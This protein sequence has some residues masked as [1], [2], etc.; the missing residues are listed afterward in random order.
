MSS[1]ESS[2]SIYKKDRS[3]DR[4]RHSSTDYNIKSSGKKKGK[5]GKINRVTESKNRKH[6]FSNKKDTTY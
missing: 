4:S 1:F 2:H 3:E 5:R 6:L